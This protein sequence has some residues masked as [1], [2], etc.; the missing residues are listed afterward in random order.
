MKSYRRGRQI[1]RVLHGVSLEIAK[2]QLA[3]LLGPSG[4]GK[5]TLLSILGCLLSADSGDLHVLGKRV[6]DFS[7]RQLASIRREYFG[8]LFQKFHLIR[9]LTAKENVVARQTVVGAQGISTENRAEDILCKVGLANFIDMDP[10]QMSVGQCQRVALAR[11]LISDPE[12]IFADEPTASLDTK[13]GMEMM[14]L[15]HRLTRENGTTAIIVTHDHRILEFADQIL[16]LSDGRLSRW[17]D[18]SPASVAMPPIPITP[19]ALS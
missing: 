15:L 19:S 6:T 16:F 11:A 8:F 18:F 14:K 17:E 7:R 1:T 12:I 4:S 13:N 2:G 5:T 9:G 10:R 3:F